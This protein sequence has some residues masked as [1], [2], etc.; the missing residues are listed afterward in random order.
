[1]KI[2]LLTISL[3]SSTPS[4]TQCSTSETPLPRNYFG[5]SVPTFPQYGHR[6]KRA[7]FFIIRKQLLQLQSPDGDELSTFL[8]FR[9]CLP[10]AKRSGD[11]VSHENLSIFLKLG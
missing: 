7:L 10:L 6:F 11:A 5:I 8:S 1:M 2:F 9:A 3:S 4:V